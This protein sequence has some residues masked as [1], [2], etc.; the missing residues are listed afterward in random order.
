MKSILACV[1]LLVVGCGDSIQALKPQNS[2]LFEI[3]NAI[4]DGDDLSMDVHNSGFVAI[5]Y[6]DCRLE[7]Y[8][9]GREVENAGGEVMFVPSGG[10]EPGETITVKAFVMPH[11]SDVRLMQRLDQGDKLRVW[12]EGKYFPVEFRPH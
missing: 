7:N 12:V 2:D 3:K 6:L 4:Y 5:E 9:P 11:N 1:V 10:I 8:T